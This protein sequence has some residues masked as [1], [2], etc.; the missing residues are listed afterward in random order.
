MTRMAYQRCLK[1]MFGLHRFGIKLEMDTIRFMLQGLGNPH[2]AFRSIHIAGTNG[3]GSI[4]AML[5]HIFQAT[6][7]RVGRYT[8]PHL[9][10]FNER[11][12]INNKPI[13]NH[14]VVSAYEK[15]RAL[16]P[17]KR[18]PTF[19]EFTT[20]MAMYEFA[21]Q[22]VEWA[23]IETGMGGRMDATNIIQPEVSIITNISLEHKAYLGRTIGAIAGEKAGIIK[24]EIP[25]ITGVRQKSALRAICEAACRVNAPVYRMGKDFSVRRQPDRSFSFNGRETT[26]RKMTIELLGHHQIQNAGLA[27][28]ACETLYLRKRAPIDEASIRAGLKRTTWPGRLEMALASPLVILDGAHNLMAARFLA[29]YLKTHLGGRRLTL[30]IGILDDKPYKQ[31]LKDLAGCCD[32]II[33]TQPAIERAIP[34]DILAR[35]ARR[36]SSK[37]EVIANVG[38][39]AK[40]ALQTCRTEDAICV[41]G[42]LYVVGE[43]KTALK[44][45]GLA[46]K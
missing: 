39:A 4:A 44:K 19:F 23:I 40:Y 38:E 35:E 10:T 3:K 13:K 9:E 7:L 33:V 5:S 26:W 14:E 1:E 6:G 28:A 22:N 15:V 2:Q 43:A 36:T 27:L 21:R 12:C 41:A 42:S 45:L 30:V 32:R 24:Q 8:S 16:A 18:H 11:I 17:P 20:A 31:M 34:A 46:Q 25:V 37:V 29:K